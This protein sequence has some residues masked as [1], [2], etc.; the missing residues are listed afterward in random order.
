M[1]IASI[2]V[3]VLA[4]YLSSVTIPPEVRQN[5]PQWFLDFA[6]TAL[7][8]GGIVILIIG[9][10]SFFIAWGFLKG[11]NWARMVALILLIISVVI[12]VFN[13][14]VAAIFT[15]EALFGLIMAIIIPALLIWYL[16]TKKVK[17]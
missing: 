4:G 14:I 7:A 13:T 16:T 8:I 5:L 1:V 6:P 10:I 17:A 15:P 9:L 11:R 3:L 2:G 12:S